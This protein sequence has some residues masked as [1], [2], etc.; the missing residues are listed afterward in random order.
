LECPGGTQAEFGKGTDRI[1]GIGKSLRDWL[2]SRR[3]INKCFYEKV[4]KVKADV[5]AL[6]NLFPTFGIDVRW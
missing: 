5:A 2:E 3:K 1:H 4:I 6:L